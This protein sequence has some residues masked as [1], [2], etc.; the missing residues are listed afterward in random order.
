MSQFPINLPNLRD[1]GGASTEKGQKV[2]NGRILRSAF[3]INEDKTQ[4]S[5]EASSK[6]GW[7]PKLVI[8]LRSEWE[9]PKVHPLVAESTRVL[10]V[11]LTADLSPEKM[12]P[13]NL[14]ES[15]QY[16][17]NNAGHQLVKMIQSIVGTDGPALVH[18]TAGK[19]RAGVS[20]ALVLRLLGV[21][22]E[23]IVND[24]MMTQQ[25]TGAISERLALRPG[26]RTR[27]PVP[28]EMLQ[29]DEEAINTVLDIWDE[30]N[31]GVFGWYVAAGGDHNDLTAL[32][33]WLLE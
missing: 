22:R 3:P 19:D 6:I 26:A 14:V 15:Y 9:R 17:V 21:S 8:D 12:Q 2:R 16:V 5:E 25:N 24:Y 31:G 27:R 20:I 13:E 7:P 18:C 28:H 4:N 33:S 30:A 11:P 10:S 29:V 23:A 32:A 1:I